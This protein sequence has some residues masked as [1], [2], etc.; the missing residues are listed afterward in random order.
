[1]IAFLSTQPEKKENVFHFKHVFIHCCLQEMKSFHSHKVPILVAVIPH[2][3][4]KS[5]VVRCKNTLPSNS[6]GSCSI[7]QEEESSPAF[8]STPTSS[9][10]W[11]YCRDKHLKGGRVILVLINYGSPIGHALPPLS[12]LA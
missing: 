2:L 3:T 9:S 5:L 10:S 12:I 8:S 4:F 7:E 6:S 1:M 11:E